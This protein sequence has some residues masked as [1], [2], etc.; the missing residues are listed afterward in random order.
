MEG[1]RIDPI[2]DHR[3][4][5]YTIISDYALIRGFRPNLSITPVWTDLLT[6]LPS[7][8]TRV[9]PSDKIIQVIAQTDIG[10]MEYHTKINV[11]NIKSTGPVTREGLMINDYELKMEG[12]E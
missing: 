3:R 5:P 10:P 4:Q 9:R 6:I 8:I 7:K 11:Q 12:K 2:T 1:C